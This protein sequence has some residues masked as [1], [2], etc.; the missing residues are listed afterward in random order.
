MKYS[1]TTFHSAGLA[2]TRFVDL[3]S[4][5]GGEPW[6]VFVHLP[7]GEAPAGG[8]P[9]LVMT[10][11]NAMIA[12]AVD[13]LRVQSSYP[14]GTN[15]GP[16]V[17]AAI[18]YPTEDAYDPLRRSFDLSPPPGRSYPPFSEGGPQVL[19]GGAT[20]F[21]DFV[22]GEALPFLDGLVPIDPSRRTLFG[23][24]FGGLFA[25]HA[26]F[27]G[28]RAFSRFV[29][30]SPT[31]YWEDA[32]LLDSERRFVAASRNGELAIHLSAG[33]HEGATLAPFQYGRDDTEKRLSN[34][35]T[36]RTLELTREMAERLSALPHAR[37]SFEVYPGETH[38]TM[39]PIAVS[40]AVRT[41]FQVHVA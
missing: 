40:R 7:L 22:E 13:A 34:A 33:E 36:A 38:M 28:C 23:H 18:G 20:R 17:I 9:L 30:A 27:S 12:T 24:S 37:V 39:L 3:E 41:A 15:V 19:T 8:W 16:G 21:L 2:Q 25:L 1:Q 29:A 5:R 26:L 32:G 4:E 35:R 11:G 6:R 14:A 31:I 10:D